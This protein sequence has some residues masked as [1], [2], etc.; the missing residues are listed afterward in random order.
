MKFSEW[1]GPMSS[2][3]SPNPINFTG[4]S[5][6]SRIA[7]TTP[8]RAVPSILVNTI[9]VTGVILK[10]LWLAP[11]HFD[12]LMHRGPARFHAVHQVPHA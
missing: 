4:I 1:N 6:S 9:P 10:I 3:F 5:N 11:R 8:P 2:I 12:R 7:R